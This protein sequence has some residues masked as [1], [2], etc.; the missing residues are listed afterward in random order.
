MSRTSA[1]VERNL[2]KRA[3]LRALATY[4]ADVPERAVQLGDLTFHGLLKSSPSWGQTFRALERNG[5]AAAAVL[6]TFQGSE[7][8]AVR[9][10]YLTEIGAQIAATDT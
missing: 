6:E 5:Y 1:D 9:A 10:W 7:R 4:G 2:R 8:P 3:A